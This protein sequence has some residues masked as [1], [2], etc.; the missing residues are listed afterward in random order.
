[1]A[2]VRMKYVKAYRDRHGRWRHYFRRPGYPGVALPGEPGSK[3]FAEAYETAMRGGPVPKAERITPGTFSAIIAEYYD[4]S[5][6]GG[7]GDSTKKTYRRALEKFRE[8][9]GPVPVRDFTPAIC[10]DVLDA[11]ASK[12]G[13]RENLR[14]PLRLVLKLAVRRGH[15]AVSPMDGVRLPRAPLKGF[16]PWSE[17]DIAQFEAHWKPGTRER[18][19]LA[20]L[21]YTVQRRSDVVVMGRQ[22][23]KP[24]KI[25]VAQAKSNGRTRLWIPIHPALQAE[26]DRVPMT[27]L[28]FLQTQYG[29][30][31]SPAGFTQWFRESAQEA[32]LQ[33][34]T[35]HG[36]RKAGSRRLAEAGCT[37]HQIMA[38]T[39][40]KNL[41][42]VTLYTASADQERLAEEAIER[43]KTSN[44][45]RSG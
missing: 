21:L 1:M 40:H 31:F 6:Y 3:A 36:L 8:T 26:I 35:P 10:D 30:P 23:T 39:G 4:S 18:L 17:A 20:L 34:R 2:T 11:L 29:E 38:V 43:T 24:G 14:K 33:D 5:K 37:P 42:E 22:H 41:S 25:H 7:L 16:T 15:I 13:A 28:T 27:Q 12:P 44:L 45:G 32:G 19:A 9:W